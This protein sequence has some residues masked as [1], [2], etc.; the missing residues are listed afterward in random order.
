WGITLGMFSVGYLLA[1]GVGAYLFSTGSITLGAVYLIFQY[2][3][4]LRRPLDQITEQL[5][6]LQ[7]ASAGIGRVRELFSIQ[8]EIKGGTGVT[9]QK[10]AH[11]VEFDN[12]SFGYG[13]EE[14]VLRDITFRLEP[15]RILGLLG[16]TGSGKTTITRLLFRLYDPASGMIRL[17]EHD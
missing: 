1:F 7:K 14:M 12:V 15:G 13:D 3:D 16:R 2:T 9:Y 17:G 8:P 11:S 5:K 10:G 6:D 4:M